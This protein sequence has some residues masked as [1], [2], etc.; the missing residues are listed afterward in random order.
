M[1]G[2]V[3]CMPWTIDAAEKYTGPQGMAKMAAWG[4]YPHACM[5]FR[6]TSKSYL[7]PADPDDP[8]N[9][10]I[11]PYWRV[12]ATVDAER[13]TVYNSPAVNLVAATSSDPNIS[14]LVYRQAGDASSGNVYLIVAANLSDK[15]ASATIMLRPEVLEMSGSYQLSRVDSRTGAASSAGAV[16]NTVTTSQLAP[17]Q[18]E[19]LKLSKVTNAPK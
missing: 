14:C 3:T 12:L 18:I 13:C 16:S 2:G 4:F 15:P 11:L 7:L 1:M 6:R 5:A 17:W 19:G 10:Y 8:A 9:A